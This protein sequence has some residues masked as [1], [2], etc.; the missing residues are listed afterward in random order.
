MLQK[1]SAEKTS[2]AS[3]QFLAESVIFQPYVSQTAG[4]L[5]RKS[6]NVGKK[7]PDAV[8]IYM[9]IN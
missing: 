6:K 7:Y 9:E 1:K 5:L 4:L 8:E 3:S 2:P